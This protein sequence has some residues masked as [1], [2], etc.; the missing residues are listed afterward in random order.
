MQKS[1][2]IFVSGNV[3][4]HKPVKNGFVLRT[5]ILSAICALGLAGNNL[6]ADTNNPDPS[7][8][9]LNLF[10]Q[11]GFIT[12][13][14]ADKARAEVQAMRTNE[15]AQVAQSSSQWKIMNGIKNVEL[16]GD[17]RLRYEGRSSTT[18]TDAKVDLQRFRYSL[19]FGFRGEAAD[20]MYYGFRLETA[21]NPRS[22]WVTFGSSSSGIPYQGPFGKSTASLNV[23]QLYFGWRPADWVDLTIGKMP[24]PLYTTP[25][26]W[27]S[28]LNPEGLAE[29]FKYNVGPMEVFATL[30]QFLYADQNPT[31]ASAGLNG[32]AVG[33][34]PNNIFMVAYQGGIIYHI[35]TNITL[36]AAG[37]VYQ[38]F[39][40]QSTPNANDPSGSPYFGNPYV[41]EGAYYGPNGLNIINGT[42]G[43][44]TSTSQGINSSL[45]YPLNQVGIN[46]LLV[47]EVPFELDFKIS[48][49]DAR[50]FGDAAYNIEGAQR[51]EAASS[52]YGT[53]LATLVQDGQPVAVSAFQPQRNEDKAYQIGFAIGNQD[54]L[55]LAYGSVSRKHAWE[56]RTYWQH[57]EQYA[58]DP[59]LIDSDFFEGAENLQGV[60][61]AFA[62]GLTDNLTGTIRYGYAS[63]INDKLGTGGSDQDIPQVNPIDKYQ[64]IQADLTFRF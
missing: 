25:M 40:Q 11:K 5:L 52:A 41:G 7:D 50:I 2:L 15:N 23:G 64:L 42:S 61:T 9:I 28:D 6:R 3:R 14:E 12:Q 10:L 63:R 8:P 57:I 49:F 13:S 30:G 31:F 17:V 56:F 26:V 39:G 48:K 53:Y 34:S 16:F 20:D 22:P 4:G 59:N 51:A 36:K 37:T 44:G 21:A 47:V 35:T 29:R 55:G 18:P 45:G 1:G 54:S 27:D 60:Y 38:Y 33:Q 32:A 58:L 19:R 46:D 62:Y 43:Y 24:N